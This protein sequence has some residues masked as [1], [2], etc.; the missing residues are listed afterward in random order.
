MNKLMVAALALLV[1]NGAAL[2]E[3]E[4]PPRVI[5][6]TGQA[7]INAVPD[8]ATVTMGVEARAKNLD[9]AQAE[10]DEVVGKFL[11]LCDELGIARKYVTATSLNI[12]PEYQWPEGGGKPRLIGFFVSRQLQVELKDLSKLGTL[13]TR[14]ISSGVT[15][16]SP[17]HLRASK[18]KELEREALTK[19]AADARLRAVALA[20]GAGV[21]LGGVRVL[22]AQQTFIPPPYPRAMAMMKTEAADMAPA[23]TYETGEIKYSA[24]VTAEFDLIP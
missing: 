23:Q 17:P 5:Q 9:D 15:N 22:N 6:V 19:A 24:T 14:A 16:V 11:Q 13:T 12:N 10:V 1:W 21:K 18:A 7:E 4:P 20:Q 8:E 3:H 2:A